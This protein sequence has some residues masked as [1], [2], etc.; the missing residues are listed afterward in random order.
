D[1]QPVDQPRGNQRHVKRA[2]AL[3]EEVAALASLQLTDLLGRV[4][5]KSMTVGPFQ[6]CLRMGEDVFVDPLKGRP[7]RVVEVLRPVTGEDVVGSLAKQQVVVGANNL[8]ERRLE[9]FVPKVKGPAAK[10]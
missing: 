9:R 7:D 5:G 3:D 8:P 2:A 10:R 6:R 1:D 4:A